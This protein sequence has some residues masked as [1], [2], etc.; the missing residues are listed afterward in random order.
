MLGSQA[1][2]GKISTAATVR[3]NPEFAG[4]SRRRW[5]RQFTG[6]IH[7]AIAGRIPIGFEDEMGFH[8][9]MKRICKKTPS[10]EELQ[11]CF[12]KVEHF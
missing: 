8:L 10:G 1:K 12:A 6:R 2:P 5:L 11:D 3:A 4:W 9:G 7:L